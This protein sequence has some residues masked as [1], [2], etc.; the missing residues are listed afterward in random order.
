M[1]Y[2]MDMLNYMKERNC[3]HVRAN[4]VTMLKELNIALSVQTTSWFEL[5]KTV[6]LLEEDPNVLGNPRKMA[7][8]LNYRSKIPYF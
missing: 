6:M 7:R 1:L 2:Q 4:Q 8:L 5:D 3:G